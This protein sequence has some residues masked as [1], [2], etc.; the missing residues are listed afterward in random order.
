M[1]SFSI[2]KT[3]AVSSVVSPQLFEAAPQFDVARLMLDPSLLRVSGLLGTAGTA[4]PQPQPAQP[5]SPTAS[6]S[7]LQILIA[8]IRPAQDGQ[9]ISA[10]DHNALRSA[11]VAIANRLG[12]GTVTEE[13][14]VTVSP[15]FLPLTAANVTGWA[16]EYGVATKPGANT[17]AVKGWLEV[18]F[19][20][21]A[22]IKKMVAYATAALTG[23]G[24]LAIRLIRQQIT[25]AGNMSVLAE[26]LVPN[27]TD[28]SKGAEADV[29]LP[30]T[31]AGVTA[32]EEFRIVNNREHKYLL[33]AEIGDATINR[34]RL[35]Y[36]GG[37]ALSARLASERIC[38]AAIR[39][40]GLPPAA[41]LCIKRLHDP[42]PETIPL[43]PD[44]GA[45]FRRPG[46]T[47]TTARWEHSLHDSLSDL[48]RRAARPASGRVTGDADAV[49]FDDRAQMLACLAADWCSGDTAARWWWRTLFGRSV[50]IKTLIGIFL[51]RPEHI[52]AA[53]EE[54]ARLGGAT[55]FV[56]PVASDDTR[57][58][59]DAVVAM[60]N[61]SEVARAIAVSPQL[62]A[63]DPASARAVDQPPMRMRSERETGR[64]VAAAPWRDIAP[65]A[66]EPELQAD[67]RLLL[68]VALTVR[69]RPALARSDR[70]A[71]AVREWRAML[72][73]GGLQTFEIVEQTFPQSY[74]HI[75]TPASTTAEAHTSPSPITL[76]PD[77][78]PSCD[79]GVEGPITQT[80]VATPAAPRKLATSSP[81]EPLRSTDVHTELG[82]LFYLLNVAIALGCYG[83]FTAPRY[84]NLEV[85][86]WDFVDVVGRA[87]LRRHID[88]PVWVLIAGLAGRE[89]GEAPDRHTVRRVRP[90][91]AAARSRLVAALGCRTRTALVRM[92]LL[93]RARVLSTPTH[94][95]IVFSLAKL[96]IEIRMSGL[97]R[98]PGWIPAADRI[99]AFH[100]D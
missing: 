96:P 17:G 45:A 40:P 83:D 19:P 4:Q 68:G 30:G 6:A 53:I 10:E 11:L 73:E 82:G 29:T 2:S 66:E 15:E 97:D 43:G 74:D 86:I 16:L 8:S 60:H 69:R 12:L 20:E 7:D 41:I 87:L 56:R 13:T 34:I 62:P 50:D 98:D 65:E 1:A 72:L 89:P 39:V 44:V 71:L 38:A 99:V 90:L 59:L 3:A 9:V 75:T 46:P 32:I 36:R 84:R 54:L 78:K 91:V 26:I 85:S 33:T 31:G 28:I 42:L 51:E 95:D 49:L 47:A 14:T 100:F 77:S 70:F 63:I 93:H 35:R 25:N 55:R 27:G 79:T 80:A 88:D 92:V 48:A 64:D 57:L 21:G 22:R 24:S 18:E 23:S 52:A 76:A 37:D 5:A 61:L 94:L 58:L 81:R 67:Q